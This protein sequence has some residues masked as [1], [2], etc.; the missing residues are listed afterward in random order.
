MTVCKGRG[1]CD[2]RQCARGGE[3]VIHDSVQGEGR[4]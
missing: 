2:T 3:G 4:V 1:G